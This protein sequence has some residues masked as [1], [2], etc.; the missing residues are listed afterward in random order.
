M[1]KKISI[2]LFILFV[3]TCFFVYAKESSFTAALKNCSPYSS[4]DNVNVLNMNVIS[5]KSIAG[6]ENNKCV[7]REDVN[8]LNVQSSVVCKLTQ[9]QINELVSVIDAYELLANYSGESPDF[10]SFDTAQNNPVSKV[11]NK[12]LQDANICNITTNQVE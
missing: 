7:Y 8:F 3:S 6:W 2:S 11:W 10:S 1:F 4:K 5:S 9:A 12:Y